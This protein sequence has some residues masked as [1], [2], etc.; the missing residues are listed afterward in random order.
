MW[1]ENKNTHIKIG[2]ISGYSTT[3]EGERRFEVT[4]VGRRKTWHGFNNMDS[5]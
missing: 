2:T 5:L 4:M 1:L 3:E